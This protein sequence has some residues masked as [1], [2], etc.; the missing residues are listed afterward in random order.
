MDDPILIVF[1]GIFLRQLAMKQSFNFPPYSKSAS[2]LLG[3]RE[4]TKC[5][6]YIQSRSIT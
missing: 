5:G 2:A 3:K 1:D 4:S 6:I